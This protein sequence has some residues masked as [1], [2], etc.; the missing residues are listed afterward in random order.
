MSVFSIDPHYRKKADEIIRSEWGGPISVSVGR[1]IDTRQIPGFVY[2][3][4]GKVIGAVTYCIRGEECE[5][6]TL[7]SYYEDK[8]IGTALIDAV[9]EAAKDQGCKRLWLVTTNDNTRA[10]RFYQKR[11]FSLAAVHLNALDQSRRIKP[12]IPLT[13]I[14]GIPL[15]HEIEFEK[16]LV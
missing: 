4:H 9:A 15:Q 1:T 13:G 8:G 11:G 2:V 3:Q 14:D 10:I 5:I 6:V 7:N 16:T 12:S